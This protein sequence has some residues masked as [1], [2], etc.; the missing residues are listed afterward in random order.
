[1]TLA[2]PASLRL[3]LDEYLPRLNWCRIDHAGIAYQLG[4]GRAAARLEFLAVLSSGIRYRL[5]APALAAPTAAD[6]L[7]ANS[8]LTGP[9]K[10]VEES[11]GQVACVA[12]LPASAVVAA[13][14]FDFANSE[15]PLAGWAE[16]LTWLAAGKPPAV[17]ETITLAPIIKT[18]EAAGYTASL[19]GSGIKATLVLPG[20][21]AEV[22]IEPDQP[23]GLK[24]S[25]TL[26][27]CGES[28]GVAV[29]V[30]HVA[31]EVNRRLLLARV[32]EPAP[33]VL[34]AEVRLTMS[35]VHE[36]WLLVAMESLATAAGLAL[37]PLAALQDP[38][39][40][41]RVMGLNERG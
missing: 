1:M 40:A 2:V 21:F 17:G 38:A 39:L 29:A 22:A 10:F 6:H 41:A 12:D 28:A 34:T 3:P 13:S 30:R 4:Q 18:L 14:E 19:D 9:V 31:V 36:A 33:G 26:A 20:R 27:T 15:S 35:R 37:R 8:A 5:D 25:F 11:D 7:A 23:C 32:S 16:C 24:L